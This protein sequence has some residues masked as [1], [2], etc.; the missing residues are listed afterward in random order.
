MLFTV[1]PDGANGL[2]EPASIIVQFLFALK[3]ALFRTLL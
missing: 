1:L 2:N 3:G